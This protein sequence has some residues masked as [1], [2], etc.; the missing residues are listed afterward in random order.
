MLKVDDIFIYSMEKWSSG[1]G[2]STAESAKDAV[3]TEIFDINGARTRGLAKG[4][5]IIRTTYSDGS[6]KTSK[7]IVK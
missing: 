3:S 6:V 1:S 4:V 7:F 2:V 5:N